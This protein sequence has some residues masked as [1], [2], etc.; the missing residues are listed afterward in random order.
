MVGAVTGTG[1]AGTEAGTGTGCATG[2][3]GGA[4]ASSLGSRWVVSEAGDGVGSGVGPGS[5]ATDGA[6]DGAILTP[7][8]AGVPT[9]VVVPLGAALLSPAASFSFA[10]FAFALRPGRPSSGT[11]GCTVHQPPLPPS[12]V[13][14]ALFTRTNI[15]LMLA[16]LRDGE[17]GKERSRPYNPLP[18]H[19]RLRLCLILFCHPAVFFSSRVLKNGNRLAI[20]E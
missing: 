1:A 17:E 6:G 12:S 5:V 18:T 10:R 20:L 2:A 15:F 8:G 4:G 13:P 19:L 3:C 7:G 14:S 11:P 16:A 9:A